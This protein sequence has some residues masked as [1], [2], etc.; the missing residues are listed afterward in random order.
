[1]AESENI[2]EAY[3]RE[4]EAEARRVQEQELQRKRVAAEQAR[5]EA[6]IRREAELRIFYN[7]H[8]RPELLRTERARR[9][10]LLRV[11]IS[12]AVITLLVSIIWFFDVRFLLIV[13]L[14][15]GLG[16]LIYLGYRFEQFRQRFKPAIVQL[17]L[18]FLNQQPNFQSLQYDPK[19]NIDRKIFARSGLFFTRRALFEGEDHIEGQI[20]EMPFQLC[21]IYVKEESRASHRFETIF[22]G[23]FV[24]AH[25]N[26]KVVGK[27]AVWPTRKA[28]AMHRSLRA[29]YAGGGRP[30]EN[31]L[32][33]NHF[34][35]PFAQHFTVYAHEGTIIQE[36]LTP[37][38]QQALVKYAQ[39]LE[40][41]EV[42]FAV[43]NQELFAAISHEYDLLE[44]SFFQ[45]NVTFE[46]IRTFYDDIESILEVIQAFDQ[47]R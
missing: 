39:I 43:D 25:F 31:T 45:T 4:Q 18:D 22:A 11:G 10:L 34:S 6:R 2:Y 14:P 46:L 1:M 33:D 36:I 7:S 9:N 23:V 12:L 17:L 24:H 3:Q 21:E 28:N 47:T 35:G 5:E 13:L 41:R 44:P 29:Y 42:Y 27:L 20:G 19:R 30:M 37:P 16:Y 8:I 15:I 32:E 38:M 26:E 40:D